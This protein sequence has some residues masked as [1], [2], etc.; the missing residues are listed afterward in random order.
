MNQ[1]ASSLTGWIDGIN[2]EYH[3]AR[4]RAEADVAA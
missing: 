4:L 3:Y 2:G 1:E